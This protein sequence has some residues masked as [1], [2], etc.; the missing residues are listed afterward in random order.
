MTTESL[1]R[2]ARAL[3]D[4]DWDALADVLAPGFVATLVHTGETFDRDGFVPF[5]RD[6]PVV[7]RFLVEDTVAT[8]DRG[9]LRARVTDGSSTWHV[10]SFATVDADGLLSEL[11]EVWADGAAP[12]PDRGG[13]AG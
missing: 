7:V 12:P 11:V 3:D 10:A 6:Y 1:S 2:F 4:R 9:V 5:N 8:A 13:S